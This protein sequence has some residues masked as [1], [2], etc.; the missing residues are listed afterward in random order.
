MIVLWF[1]TW[2]CA[3]IEGMNE[4]ICDVNRAIL[5]KEGHIYETSLWLKLRTQHRQ[6]GHM[7][8]SQFQGHRRPTLAAGFL[9][10]MYS[11]RCLTLGPCNTHTIFVPRK[12]KKTE[13]NGRQAQSSTTVDMNI[14]WL[15]SANAHATRTNPPEL[16]DLDTAVNHLMNDKKQSWV[17]GQLRLNPHDADLLALRSL[18]NM[19]EEESV[20]SF[21]ETNPQLISSIMR[22]SNEV[23]SYLTTPIPTHVFLCFTCQLA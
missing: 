9:A 3:G 8:A 12:T 11:F 10:S 1:A 20:R 18:L 17:I 23:V 21:L 7:I 2:R 5:H 13:G 16:D 19:E 22:S 14:C 6:A 4:V 15:S